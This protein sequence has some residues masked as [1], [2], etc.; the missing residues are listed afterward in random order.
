MRTIIIGTLT[1]AMP[2]ITEA[3]YKKQQITIIVQEYDRTTGEPLKREIFQPIIFNKHIDSCKAK[4]FVGK[5]VLA[6][7]WVRS[8]EV[9]KEDKTFYN[10]NLNCSEIKEA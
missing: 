3:T 4:D 1:E 5:R 9:T 6:T 8:Y 10:L 7:C 2:V